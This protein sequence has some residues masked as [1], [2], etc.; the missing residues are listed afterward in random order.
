MESKTRSRTL[1]T[2]CYSFNQSLVY[3]PTRKQTLHRQERAFTKLD[4]GIPNA[5]TPMELNGKQDKP[6]KELY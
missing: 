2:N 3:T 6:K 4:F 5:R 1:D